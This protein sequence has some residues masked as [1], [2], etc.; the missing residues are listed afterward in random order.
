MVDVSSVSY[1]FGSCG[2][3]E[4]D[5]QFWITDCADELSI[6]DAHEGYVGLK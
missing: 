5:W 4:I 2:R 3:C 1:D 6:G